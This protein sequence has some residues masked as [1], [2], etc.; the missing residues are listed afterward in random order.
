MSGAHFSTNDLVEYLKQIIPP[1]VKVTVDSIKNP[2]PAFVQVFVAFRAATSVS[3][4]GDEAVQVPLFSLNTKMKRTSL[5]NQFDPI[6][7][8]LQITRSSDQCVKRPLGWQLDTSLGI[9]VFQ[10]RLYVVKIAQ[11]WSS[12]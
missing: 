2:E 4:L 6:S 1:E 12:R 11:P 9:P 3:V 8:C 7:P 5:R 10:R